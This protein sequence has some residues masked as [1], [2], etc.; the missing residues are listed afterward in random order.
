MA[1]RR[2][3]RGAVRTRAYLS[4]VLRLS[5]EGPGGLHHDT[6]LRP[7]WRKLGVGIARGGG[8]THFTVDFTE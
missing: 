7:S 1:R 6:L 8:R 5:A 4:L 2:R 3:T